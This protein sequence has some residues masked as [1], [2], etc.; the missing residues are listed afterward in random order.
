MSN[1][2]LN[3]WIQ[4]LPLRSD[5][6]IARKVW[7]MS[8]G[9]IL[10]YALLTGVPKTILVNSLSVIFVL[11]AGVEW[12]RLK[13]PNINERIV[14]ASSLIIRTNEVNRFT[15][16]PFYV[17]SCLIAI[18]VFPHMVAALSI[19]YLVFGDPIASFI[20]IISKKH[21]I[22]LTKGKSFQGTAACFGVCAIATWFYLRYA[23]FHGTDLMRLT[24][25]GG[26]AGA[27]SELLPFEIDDNFTIPMVSGLIMWA[28]FVL[29][30][31]V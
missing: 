22:P 8:M 28:G 7:H 15:G 17:G 2:R 1:H 21:S 6:H 3:Q 5:L 23:S 19:L 26:F 20:G 24:L 27:I 16:V 11:V 13:N 12:L 4:T 9:L 29:I 14:K 30:H 25:L 10:V 18:S 31:F